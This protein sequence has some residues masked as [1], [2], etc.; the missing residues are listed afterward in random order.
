MH[1]FIR[2]AAISILEKHG[3]PAP[4]TEE[5]LEVARSVSREWSERTVR[6]E[7]PILT[8]M[9]DAA[10]KQILINREKVK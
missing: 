3:V 9:M 5:E 2:N 6:K 4:H 10:A 7:Q 8:D 1:E